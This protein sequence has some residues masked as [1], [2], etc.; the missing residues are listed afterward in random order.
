[1]YNKTIGRVQIESPNFGCD[2]EFFIENTKGEIRGSEEFV[3]E[4]GPNTTAQVIRDGVQVELNPPPQ[5]CRALLARN[6][7][8]SIRILE[9]MLTK[10]TDLKLSTKAVV[11]VEEKYLAKLS[12]Q[13]RAL[14][15]TPSNN[16]HG[17]IAITEKDKKTN[18]RSAG[19]HIHIGIADL[20]KRC[21]VEQFVMLL[22]L[23]V[24]NTAVLLD[25][26]PGQAERR[27]LYG[28]A[29]EYRLPAHGLEYRTPS[30]FWMRAYPLMG[31][32]MGMTRM[33]WS[34]VSSSS[35]SWEKYKEQQETNYKQYK[36]R[37]LEHYIPHLYKTDPEA[38]WKQMRNNGKVW[39]EDGNAIT[40]ELFKMFDPKAVA[41][42]INTNNFD[43]ALKNHEC[44][45]AI[46]DKYFQNLGLEEMSYRDRDVSLSKNCFND[47]RFFVEK[48]IDHWFPGTMFDNWRQY[49]TGE[50]HRHG[51]ESFLCY[52]VRPE[53]EAHE[54]KLR[55]EAKKKQEQPAP[56]SSTRT[57]VIARAKELEKLATKPI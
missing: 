7:A 17:T 37:R 45:E 15:C 3:P 6:I 11:H 41:E 35:N 14:G 13:A 18:L 21:N 55:E 38:Y 12:E 48:G 36:D 5:S 23:F 27:K 42:A 34:A 46:I 39:M 54:R 25:R 43:L 32:M 30:N 52:T 1:M 28:R 49:Q 47:F 2:P 19:G 53:R 26:D 57:K 56:A 40:E 24:G 9:V 50:T 33:A 29:G 8:G 4:R 20:Q 44:T 22:D 16:A 31:L 51:W 10:S